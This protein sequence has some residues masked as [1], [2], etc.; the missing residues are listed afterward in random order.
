MCY[1]LNYILANWNLQACSV[2]TGNIFPPVSFCSVLQCLKSH[3]FFVPLCECCLCPDCV[4]P[5]VA[6]LQ[7]H[8]RDRTSPST[9]WT[10]VLST[11]PV[12]DPVLPF[13]YCAAPSTV[14]AQLTNSDI[15]DLSSASI[16][17]VGIWILKDTRIFHIIIQILETVKHVYMTCAHT[18]TKEE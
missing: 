5:A 10:T 11:Y 15:N 7:S 2:E 16:P 12:S 9:L 14:I 18:W 13:L 8:P 4:V 3:L 1:F 17:R 6:A